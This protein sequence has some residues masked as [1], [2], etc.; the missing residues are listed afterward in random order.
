MAGALPARLP[1]AW[2][3]AAF[4]ALLLAFL[5]LALTAETATTSF[6]QAHALA[7]V[8]L[9]TLG[10]LT[11]T[12][13][14]AVYIALPMILQAPLPTGRG[15]T[16]ALVLVLVAASGVVSHFL[17]GGYSGVAWSGVMLAPVLAWIALRVWRALAASGAPFAIRAHVGCAFGNGI[18]AVVLGAA[19][20]WNRD[21]SWLQAGHLAGLY[22]HAHLAAGGFVAMMF[23]GMGYRLLPMLLPAAAPRGAGPWLSLGAMQVGVLGLTGAQ[24]TFPP[25]SSVFAVLLAAGLLVFLVEVARMLARRKPAPPAHPKPDPARLLLLTAMAQLFAAV[26]LGLLLGTG[27][28]LHPG[29]R[30]AYGVAGLLGGFGQAALGVGMRLLPWHAWMLVFQATKELPPP[31]HALPVR[32]LEWTAAGCW[33]PGTPALAVG[34]GLGDSGLV[35]AAALVLA[36][37]TVAAGVSAFTAV[38]RASQRREA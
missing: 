38:R 12:I 9:V 31:P 4:C 37:G 28:L 21:H 7:A 24:L 17:L 18:L 6:A 34:M 30:S 29:W 8:H 27:L 32:S 25:T 35:R 36:V 23:V 19:I 14:G 2:F 16:V 13:L 20:A 10:W 11:C 15:D 33:V 3:A 1:R 5:L 22:A 26:V